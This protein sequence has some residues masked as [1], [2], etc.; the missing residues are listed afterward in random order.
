MRAAKLAERMT[1]KARPHVVK[2]HH[3]QPRFVRN[4]PIAQG[5]PGGTE[6]PDLAL[7]HEHDESISGETNPEPQPEIRQA[8]ED[9]KA[10]LVDTDMRATPGLDARRRR[11]LLRPRR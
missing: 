10:G 6:T 3:K 7:P 4:P 9:L 5:A 11:A 2:T 1:M 8:Y